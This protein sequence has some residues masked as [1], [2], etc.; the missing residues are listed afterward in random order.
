MGG[1]ETTSTGMDWL[2]AELLRNPEVMKKVQEEVR[3]VVGKKPKM[4]MNDINQMDY[5]KCVMKETLRL[6]PPIPLLVPRG[7]SKTIELGG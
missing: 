6:H 2:M 4:D 5:L 7:T 1:S 3:R